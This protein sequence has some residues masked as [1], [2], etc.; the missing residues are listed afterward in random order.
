VERR[1]EEVKTLGRGLEA[2]NRELG[3]K[4]G[5]E[6]CRLGMDAEWDCSGVVGSK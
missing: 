1:V 2:V 4:Y 5:K 3:M 6:G